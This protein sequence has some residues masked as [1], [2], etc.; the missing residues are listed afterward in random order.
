MNAFWV[1]NISSPPPIEFPLLSS[2]TATAINFSS[3]PPM[4]AL[5]VE[6]ISSP[7]SPATANQIYPPVSIRLHLLDDLHH[8]LVVQHVLLAL[9]GGS[10]RARTRSS[11]EHDS[12]PGWMR[13]KTGG[14][15]GGKEEDKVEEEE[16]E[17]EDQDKVHCRSS[18]CSQ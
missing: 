18:A 11:S 10:L 13:L 5:R 16:E 4:N 7:P 14:G 8:V 9:A 12:S 6:K 1:E 2:A 3:R 15:G 17:E